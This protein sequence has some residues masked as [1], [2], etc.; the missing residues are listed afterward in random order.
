MR[1][2]RSKKYDT[3]DI[4]ILTSQFE[5]HASIKKI[6][7]SYPEIVPHTFNFTLVSAEDVKKKTNYEPER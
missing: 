2:K 5:D 4:D 6:K 1:L 3:N 7:L